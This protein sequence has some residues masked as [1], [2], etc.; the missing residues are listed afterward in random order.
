M[1]LMDAVGKLYCLADV[2]RCAI[3]RN[4]RCIRCD[5]EQ[6]TP[7]LVGDNIQITHVQH[8]FLIALNDH[9]LGAACTAA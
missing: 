3:Y 5:I 9:I 2:N 1:N 7:R 8:H 6:N 4:R